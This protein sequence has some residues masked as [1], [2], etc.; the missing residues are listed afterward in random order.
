V[1]D[2]FRLESNAAHVAG[3]L[4]SYAGRVGQRTRSTVRRHGA[5]L[6]TKVKRN[7]S[8]PRTA[9]RGPGTGGPRLLTGDYNRTIGVTFWGNA[10][11]S[12]ATV[13]TNKDQGR[14][15]E[16][17]FSGTDSLGRVY[18]QPPYP[19]FGPAFEEQWPL[20]LAE[21]HADTDPGP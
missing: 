9:P 8:L 12:S 20:F 10:A 21:L 3:M 7:A 13:G 15:L 6:Q 14:R 11:A 19:H 1:S 18:D 17:G 4:D 2:G 5:L 16:L